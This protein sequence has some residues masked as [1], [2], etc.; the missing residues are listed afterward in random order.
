MENTR[1]NNAKTMLWFKKICEEEGV[2]FP[3]NIDSEGH[4]I[5]RE[6]NSKN[7]NNDK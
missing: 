1:E 4:V 5:P 2:E 6:K 3:I 7:N